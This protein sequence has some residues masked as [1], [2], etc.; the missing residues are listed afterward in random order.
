MSTLNKIIMVTLCNDFESAHLL[1]F[2]YLGGVAYTLEERVCKTTEEV[3]G[4]E[5]YREG[6]SSWASEVLGD[7]L[8][9]WK[10]YS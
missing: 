5:E 7:I 10:C 4:L 2:I 1:C 8:T 3:T 6:V 9:D